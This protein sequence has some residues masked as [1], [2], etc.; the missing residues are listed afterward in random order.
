MPDFDLVSAFYS[1]CTAGLVSGRST[2]GQ[3]FLM[4]TRKQGD[5]MSSVL[6]FNYFADPL[7]TVQSKAGVGPKQPGLRAGFSNNADHQTEDI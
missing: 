1:P 7:F 5:K 3:L 2:R 4:Q 6:R